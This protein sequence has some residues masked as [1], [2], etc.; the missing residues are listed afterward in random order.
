MQYD[1]R[2]GES[3]WFDP[4][5][6]LENLVRNSELLGFSKNPDQLLFAVAQRGMLERLESSSKIVANMLAFSNGESGF[7]AQEQENLFRNLLINSLRQNSALRKEFYVERG[8]DR[9]SVG[10]GVFEDT[11]A[12]GELQT[13]IRIRLINLR[14]VFQKQWKSTWGTHSKI[15]C[16]KFLKPIPH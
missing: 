13:L 9:W 6:I 3:S 2:P 8:S 4:S 5:I 10:C 1:S 15:F 14:S 12:R 7:E 11:V 16:M